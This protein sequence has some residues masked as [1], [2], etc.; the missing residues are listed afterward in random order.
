MKFRFVRAWDPILSK[1][2]NR[3][4]TCGGFGELYSDNCVVAV[5]CGS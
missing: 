1:M 5:L 4:D 3:F 2:T